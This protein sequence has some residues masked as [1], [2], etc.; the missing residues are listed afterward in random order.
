MSRH[1]LLSLLALVAAIPVPAA[2][3]STYAD[4]ALG[5]SLRYPK[6]FVVQ[7]QDVA[8]LARFAPAPI[9]SIFFMSPAM[10]AGGLAGIEPPDLEVRIYRAEASDSLKGWLVSV[11]MATPESVAAARPFQNASVSGLQVCRSTMVAPN[12]SVYVLRGD[13]VY[14]LTAISLE[15]EA[16]IET[17]TLK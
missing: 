2:D 8:K 3:G 7:L 4:P 11:G 17:F 6:G 14:Q 13:R 12:C 10:A 1:L 5:W 9:A 15:G 16:M